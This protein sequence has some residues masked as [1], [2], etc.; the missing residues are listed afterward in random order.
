MRAR[1]STPR[2]TC[3]GEGDIESPGVGNPKRA[4]P[5][6]DRIRQDIQQRL[7]RLL[8]EGEKLRG[9]LV[10]LDPRE[11]PSPP[12]ARRAT[13]RPAPTRTRSPNTAKARTG[14]AP[15][16]TKTKVL[17]ALTN[18][19][20]MTAGEVATATGLKR[21][22]VSTTLSKCVKTGEV[23]K[24]K[25]GYRLPDNDGAATAEANAAEAAKPGG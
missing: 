25:R 8:A 10:A 14:T 6:I 23:I 24:A 5:L 21:G 9:A 20:A 3:L 13:Q 4:E 18:G 12:P 22:T 1:R 17:D 15:G 19:E 16:A 7:D 2:S 11:R